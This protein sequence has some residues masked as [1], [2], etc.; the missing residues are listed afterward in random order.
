MRYWCPH[1]LRIPRCDLDPNQ[2]AT[3]AIF[4]TSPCLHSF[5]NTLITF[6]PD[7]FNGTFLLV[8]FSS[9]GGVGDGPY[10]RELLIIK[11]HRRNFPNT[12]TVRL[13]L[14]RDDDKTATLST[15]LRSH[16][17]AIKATHS[18]LEEL[19]WGMHAVPSQVLAVSTLAA[20]Y[21]ADGRR[22]TE[23]LLSRVGDTLWY[24]HLHVHYLLWKPHTLK[25]PGKQEGP[26]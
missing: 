1:L 21:W 8:D 9:F 25:I 18:E 6:L 10:I 15:G 2:I 19:Q 16:E 4:F 7:S 24:L 26:N 5:I 20:V 11:P 13:S 23:S 17:W 22:E 3:S 12:H 14:Q